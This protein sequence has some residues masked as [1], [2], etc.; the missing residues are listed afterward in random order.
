[1]GCPVYCRCTRIYNHHK[2][3]MRNAKE[4]K[5]LSLSILLM[6]KIEAL[7]IFEQYCV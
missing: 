3:E 2:T 4:K 6:L 1:M 7:R 5:K